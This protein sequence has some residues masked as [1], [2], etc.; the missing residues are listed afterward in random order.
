M[1][2]LLIYVSKLVHYE[3]MD[4]FKSY[5]AE[6]NASGFAVLL[7]VVPLICITR[8]AT[9]KMGAAVFMNSRVGLELMKTKAAKRNLMIKKFVE[10]FWKCCYYTFVVLYAFFTLITEPSTWKP[11]ETYPNRL[12]N[13]VYFFYIVQISFYMWMTI[14]LAWDVKRKDFYQMGVH[15]LATLILL[16]TSFNYGCCHIGCLVML[17]HDIADPFLEL[18]KMANY[19]KQEALSTAS[20]V[21]F[22][23]AFFILR[24]V[25][26]PFV[27]LQSAW[28]DA[29][30]HVPTLPPAVYYGCN[31][32]LW[33]L[34]VLNI[35]WAIMIG[36]V[37]AKKLCG[38][39]IKDSRSEDE[40]E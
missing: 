40:S 25:L 18:A 12:D 28:V 1:S 9:E 39:K 11:F 15:H 33:L 31:I 14:C 22:F 24:L 36:K 19:T 10:S 32:F 38:E 13:K 27:A 7:L 6:F 16:I 23:L 3:N 30:N 37:M 5:S 17:V 2:H 21:C 29:G 35:M 8:L 34:L 20:F 26:F 4:K